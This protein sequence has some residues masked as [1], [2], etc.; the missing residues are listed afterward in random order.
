M[1]G[2]LKLLNMNLQIHCNATKTLPV[3]AE[4][5]SL[6]NHMSCIEGIDFQNPKKSEKKGCSVTH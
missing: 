1:S 2:A 6:S 5:N 3:D 4:F